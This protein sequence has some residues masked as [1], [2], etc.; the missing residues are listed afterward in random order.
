MLFHFKDCSS[1]TLT[2]IPNAPSLSQPIQMRRHQSFSLTSKL[3]ISCTQQTVSIA[4]QWTVLGCLPNCSNEIQLDNRLNTTQNELFIQS[5]TLPSGIYEFK[6][7]TTTTTIASSS[8]FIEIIDLHIITNLVLFGKLM[9]KHHSNQ[10]LILDPGN[11]SI[12]PNRIMFDPTVSDI[13]D[14]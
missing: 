1:S 8:I 11:Y 6:L 13:K 12:D 4:Y 3:D 9:I 7:S 2:L 14:L 5:Q 10:I